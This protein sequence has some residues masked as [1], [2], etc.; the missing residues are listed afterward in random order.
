MQITST[1]PVKC[2][3]PIIVCFACRR[4]SSYKCSN[5]L[6]DALE[7]MMDIEKTEA[8]TNDYFHFLFVCYFVSQI[9]N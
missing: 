3:T 9:I 1:S 4:Q 7:K 5:T 8:A 6:K 2:T